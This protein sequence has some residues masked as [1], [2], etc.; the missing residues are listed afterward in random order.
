MKT[1]YRLVLTG[2][3]LIATVSFS[4]A[5]TRDFF[6]L[7]IYQFKTT[8][9]QSRTENYLEKALLPALHRAGIK[10]I[11]VFKPVETDST[12]GK[13]LYLLIP[14]R[15]LDQFSSQTESLLKDKTYLTNG[16]DYLDATFD[17]PPYDRIQTIILNAFSGMPQLA[18]PNLKAPVTERVYELRSYEGYTEKI[19]RNKVDMFN[20][21][22]E[23]GL[24][25]RLGFNAVFYGEVLSGARMPNLM[26]MTTFEN[27]ASRDAHWK[28]FVDDPQWKK[29]STMPEYQKNVSRIEIFF[30]RPTGYSDI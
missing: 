2:L 21:G 25:N 10:N 15:S 8:E 22:D 5:T 9:Q 19:Y 18:A 23:I 27:Q 17:N 6:E 20:A 7:R 28:A 3:F 14:H 29:L 24:F 13:R 11:G 26:Y 4:S 1:Y 30:L 12:S 16:K